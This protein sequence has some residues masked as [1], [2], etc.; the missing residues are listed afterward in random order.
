MVMVCHGDFSVNWGLSDPTSFLAAVPM[1]KI[2]YLFGDSSN[3]LQS[4]GLS[5]ASKNYVALTIFSEKILGQNNESEASVGV[6]CC[7]L[8][9]N[10]TFLIFF[11]LPQTKAEKGV[12]GMEDLVLLDSSF[13]KADEHGVAK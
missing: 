6:R 10:G 5:E 4:T 13:E 12:C 11:L 7:R 2:I 8:K 1:V 3:L 9:R